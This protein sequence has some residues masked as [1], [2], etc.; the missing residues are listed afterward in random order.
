MA[1]TADNQLKTLTAKNSVTGDQVTAWTYGTTRPES[2]VASNDLLRFKQYADGSASDRMEY[3][4]M[5]QT[6]ESQS[7]EGAVVTGTPAV[8]YGYT[9]GPNNHKRRTTATYPDA[10]V[11]EYDYGSTGG[12]GDV[13][14]DGANRRVTKLTGIESRNHYYSDQW[15]VL[16]ERTGSNANADR[17]YFWGMRS[18]D[19]LVC[20]DHRESAKSERFYALH[21]YFSV[22]AIVDVN[23]V[24]QERY[25]YD[26]FGTPRYMDASFG[27]RSSSNYD[28]ETLY[29]GYRYD[30]ETGLYQVRNRYLHPK[31][32]RWLS[33]DPIDYEGGINL[34]AYALNN[35]TN[36]VD[37][38]GDS[39]AT[40]GL[41]VSAC[42]LGLESSDEL[43]HLYLAWK[44]PSQ[45]PRHIRRRF[46]LEARKSITGAHL[47]FFLG[48]FGR[49]LGI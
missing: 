22:A 12:A 41:C 14:N 25:G 43:R 6:K 21:D 19:D 45:L 27:S 10:T 23:G 37:P 26:G 13:L 35:P 28:W 9:D 15:Q 20:R 18:I 47:S 46:E 16:E 39:P 36:L 5:L 48:G 40:F 31:P 49:E 11:L 17:R 7:H 3:K 32:G 44:D 2:V 29:A 38:E 42:F 34:Y 4:Y 1:Y 33:R 24:A 8:Q 30:L